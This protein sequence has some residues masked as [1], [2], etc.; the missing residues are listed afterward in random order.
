[1]TWEEC[2][3]VTKMNEGSLVIQTILDP[4]PP[5]WWQGAVMA[6]EEF[7]AGRMPH[8]LE[9]DLKAIAQGGA[10]LLAS[11]VVDATGIVQQ[12]LTG[13]EPGKEE[14]RLRPGQWRCERSLLWPTR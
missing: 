12:L 3:E 8:R 2:L 10:K 14:Y 7:R 6:Y 9:L 4:G 13:Q 11:T 1:M 5:D